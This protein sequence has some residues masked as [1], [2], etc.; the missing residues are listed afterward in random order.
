MVT[1]HYDS[2]KAL[3]EGDGRFRNAGMEYDLSNLQPTFRLKDGLPGRSYAL[4]IAARMGFPDPI[5]DRAKS[6]LGTATRGLEDVLRS[7]E[8]KEQALEN[9]TQQLETTQAELARTAAEQK[10]AAQAL[11]AR[12][13][14]LG[15]ATRT[16]VESALRK[17]EESVA[18]IV[19]EVRRRRTVESADA[20]KKAIRQTAQRL[21]A[22]LPQKPALDIE[23]LKQ[24]LTNR[25]FSTTGSGT[26]N[27]KPSQKPNKNG[28]ANH[29]RH[30][31]A[32]QDPTAP[33]EDVPLAVR[34]GGN[35]LDIRGKRADEALRELEDFLDKAALAGRDALFVIHGH[36]TGALR[37]VVREFLATSGYVARFRG[38]QPHEGGDGVSVVALRD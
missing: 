9:A 31:A 37:R 11:N 6:L 17:A 32:G 35:T 38:G 36:G 16:A 12:E 25:S 3:T 28:G 34:T 24:A 23:K 14:E 2:L 26:A 8:E 20:A 29:D 5:L 10:A 15:L 7:L 33:I 30:G 13:R 4:D 22:E 18:Q 27:S 1:T 19:A 21:T